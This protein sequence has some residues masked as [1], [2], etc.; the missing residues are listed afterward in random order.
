MTD[1]RGARSR[2]VRLINIALTGP[3]ILL[4]CETDCEMTR[5][6]LLSIKVRRPRPSPRS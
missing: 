4:A 2:R 1:T 6:I 3:R 5:E